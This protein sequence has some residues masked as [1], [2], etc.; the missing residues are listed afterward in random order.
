MWESNPPSACYEH[1]AFNQIA[2]PRC[3]QFHLRGYHIIPVNSG[4]YIR[5]YIYAFA[6]TMTNMSEG[7]DLGAYGKGEIETKYLSLLQLINISS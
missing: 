2:N 4:C 3:L 6:P 5:Y 7:S 1:A